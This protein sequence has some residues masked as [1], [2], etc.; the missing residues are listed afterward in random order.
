MKTIAI[1]FFLLILNKCTRCTNTRR[2]CI[3][4][5][6]LFSSGTTLLAQAPHVHTCG[7]DECM[8]W[9]SENDPDYFKSIQILQNLAAQSNAPDSNKIYY[10]PVVFHIIADSQSI[11]NAYTPA[12]IQDQLD[13]LNH[14]FAANGANIIFCLAQNLPIGI[15]KTQWSQFGTST[16]QGPPYDTLIFPL[17]CAANPPYN[18]GENHMDYHEESC[19]RVLTKEQVRTMRKL[20]DNDRSF[21]HS[22][23][24]LINTGVRRIGG[25][26]DSNIISA[27]FTISADE[28]CTE[29]TLTLQGANI[30]YNYW[31]WSYSWDTATQCIVL[32]GEY[33]VDVAII[34]T[35]QCTVYSDTVNFEPIIPLSISISQT[36]NICYGAA[37]GT[38]TVSVSNGALPYTYTWSNAQT[39]ATATGLTAGVYYVTVTDD[40]LTDTITSVT[41]TEPSVFAV[42]ATQIAVPCIGSNTGEAFANVSGGVMPYTYLWSNAQT[43]A[44]ATDLITG[45]YIVTVTDSN[46]C[47]AIDTITISSH[48]LPTVIALATYDTICYGDS[49][50]LTGSGAVS[51]IWNNGVSNGVIF[52]PDSTNTYTVTGTDSNGCE[53]IDSITITVTP[54]LTMSQAVTATTDSSV[55]ITQV[56]CATGSGMI[57]YTLQ[58]TIPFDWHLISGDTAW[59]A[60]II[61]GGCDTNI[62]VIGIPAEPNFCDLGVD[63]LTVL[64]T[65]TCT[66]TPYDSLMINTG[67]M[68]GMPTII[69]DSVTTFTEAIQLG[70]LLDSINAAVT[71][72]QVVFQGNISIVEQ[73]TYIFIHSD[74]QLAPNVQITIFKGVTLILDSTNV[75]GC[76]QLWRSITLNKGARLRILNGSTIQ[77]GLYAVEILHDNLTTSSSVIAKNSTF[78]NNYTA[79]YAP[80]VPSPN[81]ASL[82]ISQMLFSGGALLPALGYSPASTWAYTGLLLNDFAALSISGISNVSTFQNLAN[83]IVANRSN[84]TI[85]EAA[86]FQ[87]I[88]PYGVSD[89]TAI[90]V[91]N[92]T[93]NIYNL[94]VQGFGQTGTPS[95]DSCQN[96]IISRGC[97]LNVKENNM[98]G[99]K[100]KAIESRL[101]QNRNINITENNIQ[102]HARTGAMGIHLIQNDPT[103]STL[104]SEN[105]LEIGPLQP[106]STTGIAF[107]GIVL[108]EGENSHDL[109]I[110]ENEVWLRRGIRGIDVEDC[111]S[112]NIIFNTV[113]FLPYRNTTSDPT[114]TRTGI[115]LAACE[116]IYL[117]CNN[118]TSTQSGTGIISKTTGTYIASTQVTADCNTHYR[119]AEG[120]YLIG[121]CNS[122]EIRGNSFEKNDI[123]LYYKN[124]LTVTGTQTDAGNMWFGS[125]TGKAAARHDGDNTS[126]GASQYFVDSISP[127]IPPTISKPGSTATWFFAIPNPDSNATFSCLD[128]PCSPSMLLQ[129]PL[130]LNNMDVA[131][132]NNQLPQNNGVFSWE[133]EKGLYNKLDK[134]PNFQ[135]ISVMGQF[136]NIHQNESIGAVVETD[137]DRKTTMEIDSIYKSTLE[138]LSINQEVILDTLQILDSLYLV[139]MLNNTA[140]G[141]QRQYWL[142]EWLQNHNNAATIC[143]TL[144]NTQLSESQ[145]AK[146]TNLMINYTNLPEENEQIVNDIYLETVALGNQNFTTR[147]IEILYDI[148]HQCPEIGGTSV[149]RARSIYALIDF[150]TYDENCDSMPQTKMANIINT[151]T[152]YGEIKFLNPS[153]EGSPGINKIPSPW[154][155]CYGSPDVFP[156]PLAGNYITPSNG[157]SYA[158]IVAIG[159]PTNFKESFGQLLGDTLIAGVQY[160]F[161]FDYATTPSYVGNISMW[162]SDSLCEQE[163]LVYLA[164]TA[165]TFWHTHIV[166]F[167]PNFN[168]T[169]FKISGE[170]HSIN[171]VDNLR[172][173]PNPASCDTALS[174]STNNIGTNTPNNPSEN[175]KVYPNPNIQGLLTIEWTA[176]IPT[177]RIEIVDALGRVVGDFEITNGLNIQEL[178]IRN[179][180]SGSYIVLLKNGEG[181]LGRKKLVVMKE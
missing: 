2:L 35:Q 37:V 83:G 8:H 158:H 21:I 56:V 152:C 179:L 23:L 151:D 75:H 39:T 176:N 20:L 114:F 170:G 127:F 105:T 128:N 32:I 156:Y 10:I 47:Q 64:T 31:Q 63:I 65:A 6:F 161:A 81:K 69:P 134:N 85:K 175:F 67:T 74:I 17:T 180:P 141:I 92:D 125:W 48:S 172:S 52:A 106:D 11:L 165:D 14:H 129:A 133:L 108:D 51:Y 122:S 18:Q 136:Y 171:L 77:D 126:V 167:I 29:T 72:Q 4:F 45:L 140:W 25:C 44:S 28:V 86:I 111:N 73:D 27:Q 148:A 34:Q 62:I 78:Q 7:A 87:N 3:L 82:I 150:D 132:I 131:V 123:G 162:I 142:Q 168:C 139:G 5:C 115:V 84:I 102:V 57:P 79:I 143:N 43:N 138:Q 50:T 80:P 24:N 147:Q 116:D 130:V 99:I 135:S 104:I 154:V 46:N 9:R 137:D 144:Y 33:I 166:E 113:D 68:P 110:S 153:L 178:D 12:R 146:A 97:N 118:L 124:S 15:A 169:H 58:T 181:I 49:T 109:T 16:T 88:L 112:A 93:L 94:F 119:P 149:Y 76:E 100:I 160:R 41:I 163:Q 53:N 89:G 157:T 177:E 36:N 174:N 30:R 59:N 103:L 173:L 117:G 159:S 164:N 66:P 40:C 42:N 96:G 38:A 98:Q 26:L 55:T 1:L 145:Q 13:T 107:G 71:P 19:L 91:Q 22:D 120:M 101:A 90:H 60:S 95:F 121:N 155:I 70:L 61:A 54:I